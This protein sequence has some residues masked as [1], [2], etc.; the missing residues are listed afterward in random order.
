MKVLTEE[1]LRNH[2]K[3]IKSKKY[4]ISKE[5]LITPSAQQ[6]L[7][8]NEIELIVDEKSQ[9]GK[10]PQENLEAIDKKVER[11]YK[12]QCNYTGGYFEEKPEYMTHLYGDK[13]VYKDH[14]RIILRGKLDSLQSKILEIQILVN[15]NKLV[16]LQKDLDELLQFIRNI[17][18]AEVLGEEL[19]EIKLFGLGEEEIREISHHPEKHFKFKHVLPHYEMGDIVIGLNTLRSN[20]RETEI[21]G[22][23]AFKKEESI[24]RQDILIALNR[25]SSG[26]YLLMCRYLGGFYR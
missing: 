22:I 11:K 15:K 6:Y 13:L 2:Y 12:Y 24:E 19:A 3:K 8:D 17:L 7:K 18:R 16:K 9:N 20:A 14:P 23:Q 5:I 25:L 1:I 21:C 26:I 4:V 10:N